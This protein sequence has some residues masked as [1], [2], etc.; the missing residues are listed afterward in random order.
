MQRPPGQPAPGPRQS[1]KSMQSLSELQYWV[2]AQLAD[3][4]QV[5]AEAEVEGA[6]LEAEAETEAE[7]EA[8]A[9]ALELGALPPLKGRQALMPLPKSLPLQSVQPLG[10]SSKPTERGLRTLRVGSARAEV[11]NG[12]SLGLAST[13][14]ACMLAEKEQ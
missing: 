11:R 6:E 4:A 13:C 8:L 3:V 1:G 5:T 7:A 12:T 2:E 9:L 10:F 14:I